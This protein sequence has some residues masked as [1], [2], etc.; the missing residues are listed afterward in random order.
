MS[1]FR[2][3]DVE[4]SDKQMRERERQSIHRHYIGRGLNVL[5]MRHGS[6]LA[7]L[8]TGN[9]NEPSGIKVER[10][11]YNCLTDSLNMQF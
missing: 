1:D 8:L 5:P 11:I 10:T 6:K 9:I 2:L 7:R 3:D 4:M